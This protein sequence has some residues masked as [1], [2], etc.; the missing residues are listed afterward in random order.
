MPETNPTAI[1]SAETVDAAYQRLIEFGVVGAVLAIVLIALLC[2]IWW[3]LVQARKKDVEHQ[4]AIKDQATKHRETIE[5][6]SKEHRDMLSDQ[7]D[8]YRE[9]RKQLASDFKGRM[10]NYAT[11]LRE[12]DAT[13]DRVQEK[14]VQMAETAVEAITK[15]NAQM[16]R[17]ILAMT[18]EG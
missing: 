7:A 3:N 16:D 8:Q 4:A 5:R 12:K 6:I 18:E 14:R 9:E 10:E 11:V 15:T 13:L 1:P 2:I 17:L